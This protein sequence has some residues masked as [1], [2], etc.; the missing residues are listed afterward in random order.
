MY[1]L[2]IGH[3]MGC[4]VESTP[5]DRTGEGVG[6]V[7]CRRLVSRDD[8]VLVIVDVQERLAATMPDRSAV[9]SAVSRL[10]RTATLLGAPIIVTR[11]YP[12]GLG[13]TVAELDALMADLEGEGA[14]IL[15]VDKTTFSC[16]A[17]ALFVE[18]LRLTGRNQVVLTGMETHICVIQTALALAELGFDTQ[19]PADA[20]CSREEKAHRVALDRMR[21]AGVTVT[22]S[23]SVM[24]E[25]VGRA[26]TDEFRRLLAIVKGQ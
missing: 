6:L 1:T 4:R 22:M 11:Q 20:C 13:C 19:V 5:S 23:E 17:E 25:A 3:V 24:Y 16:V 18:A 9:I 8:L 12:Q 10:A 7:A 15:R 2:L 26:A 14:Q 21:D